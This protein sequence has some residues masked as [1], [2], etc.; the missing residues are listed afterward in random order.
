MKNTPK[1]CHG[2][3]NKLVHGKY[4]QAAVKQ[5]LSRRSNNNPVVEASRTAVNLL[6][7][8]HDMPLHPNAVHT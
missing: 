2:N 5:Y 1:H 8:Q 4:R 7:A 6:I 3:A